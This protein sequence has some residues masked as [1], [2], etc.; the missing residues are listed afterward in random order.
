MTTQQ[1]EQPTW[2]TDKMWTTMDKDTCN[3]AFEQGE[4]QLQDLGTENKDITRN[5]YTLLS[6]VLAVGTFLIT[7]AFNIKNEVFFHIAYVLA[8]A[9]ENA[10]EHIGDVEEYFVFNIE[11]H[12]YKKS[13]NG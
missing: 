5:C 10:C 13:P 3:F 9:S 1:Q 7:M 6:C 4:K 11:S 12:G 2:L 8:Y